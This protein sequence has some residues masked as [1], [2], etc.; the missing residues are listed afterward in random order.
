[1]KI[2]SSRQNAAVLIRSIREYAE[3]IIGDE[4]S[5]CAVFQAPL[6]RQIPSLL[7]GSNSPTHEHLKRP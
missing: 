6:A 3:L 7:A 2:G 1:M 5:L 4:I